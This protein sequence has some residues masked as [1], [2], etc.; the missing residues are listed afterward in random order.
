MT[1]QQTDIY[2]DD[3]VDTS[4]IETCKTYVEKFMEESNYE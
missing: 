3:D 1:E 4:G 2:S